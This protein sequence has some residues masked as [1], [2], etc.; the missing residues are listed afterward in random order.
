MITNKLHLYPIHRQWKKE[1]SFFPTLLSNG[2]WTWFVNV[3]KVRV[4]SPSGNNFNYYINEPEYLVLLLRGCVYDNG[5]FT[6]EY[7]RDN[8]APW[9]N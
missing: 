3:Y 9:C 2:N 8:W 1:F 5:V 6:S 7:Y 4:Q